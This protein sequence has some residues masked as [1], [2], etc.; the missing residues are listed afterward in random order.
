MSLN[1]AANLGARDVRSRSIQALIGTWAFLSPLNDEMTVINSD[2]QATQ[3]DTITINTGTNNHEYTLEIEGVEISYTADSSTS[4]TEVATGIA[5]AWNDS[6]DA[7]QYAYAESSSAVVTITGLTPDLAYTI[8]Q[9]DALCTLANTQAAAP[10]STVPIGRLMVSLGYETD[11]AGKLAVLCK[12]SK[13][14]AQVDTLAVTYASGEVYY[15][16]IT[17]EGVRYSVAVAADTDTAT[18]QA[19][20]VTAINAMMPTYTVLAAGSSPN[21]TLTAEVA[22]KAFVVDLGLKSGTTARLTITHTTASLLTDVNRALV[23]ISKW[24]SALES[25]TIGDSTPVW[26]ANNGVIVAKRGQL[27]VANSQSPAEGDKV[28]VETGVTADNGKLFNSPSATR[29]LLT[30][31]RWERPERSTQSEGMAVVSINF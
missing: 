11:E 6:A 31:A 27:W 10:A 18:T 21:V 8:D 28:Y 16:G 23:G 17:I 1:T 12:S 5:A 25:S 4:T 19:A 20:I 22:G 15:V 9:V 29:I 30:N 2:P 7:G 13:L 3:I 14:V 26:P 24:W